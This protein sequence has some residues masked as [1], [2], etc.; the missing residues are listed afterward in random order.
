M[1]TIQ[2]ILLYN[3]VMLL[4]VTCNSPTLIAMT[5]LNWPWRDHDLSTCHGQTRKSSQLTVWSF[6]DFA[7]VRCEYQ[8]DWWGQQEGVG[9]GRTTTSYMQIREACYHKCAS[10]VHG[11]FVNSFYSLHGDEDGCFSPRTRRLLSRLV[12]AHL[13]VHK[14]LAFSRGNWGRGTAEITIKTQL[15]WVALS[16]QRS[17]H[18]TDWTGTTKKKLWCWFKWNYYFNY[19][20]ES[21]AA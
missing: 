14:F 12:Y 2:F 1:I 17:V 13:G 15:Y 18:E 6:C 3:H 7:W 16:V 10:G 5:C 11:S 9:G 20:D 4:H 8:T 21:R 19:S